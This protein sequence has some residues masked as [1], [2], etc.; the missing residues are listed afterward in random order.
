M[1]ATWI[2]AGMAVLVGTLSPRAALG[3]SS[4]GGLGGDT[5]VVSLA[6]AEELA[7]RNHPTVQQSRLSVSIAE[8]RRTQARNA[9][10]VPRLE[11]TNVWGPIPRARGEFT[12]TGVL[13]SPD[14]ATSLGDLRWFTEV[15]VE[16]L[17]PLYTFGKLS[18]LVDAAGFGLEASRSGLEASSDEVRLEVRT[19]YW[20]L[21][22]GQE[23]VD[24]ADDVLNRLA[25]ADSILQRQYDE[26]IATQNDLFKFQIFEYQV[27][28]RRREARD[29]HAMVEAGLRAMLGIE[30]TTPLRAEVTELSP[31]PADL[32]SLEHYLALAAEDRPE[33]AQL[34]AGIAARNALTRSRRG[35][36]FPQLFLGADIRWNRAPSRFDPNN[37]F[38]N[39]PTNFFRPGVALGFRWNMNL[40]QTRDQVRLAEGETARLRGQVAPLNAKIRLEVREAYLAVGRA[41]SDVDDSEAALTASSNWFRA[42]SQTFDLGLSEINDLVD[43]FQAN[44]EMRTEHLGNIFRLNTALAKLSRAVGRDLQAM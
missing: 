27:R 15:S 4:E 16:M 20:G 21:V 11:L 10:F 42:E 2:A 29:R 12:D 36:L 8:S 34:Q 25:E 44:I 43:A 14:T 6:E 37:P 5:L 19:L 3:Q 35:E 31:L 33:L 22:L 28:R 30:T 17:Q 9:R 24:I 41:R 26:G 38:V 13:V 40:V 1:R 7:L 23:L 18:G 32:R 39:N